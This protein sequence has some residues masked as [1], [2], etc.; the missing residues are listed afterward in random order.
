MKPSNEPPDPTNPDPVAYIK[1]WFMY[2]KERMREKRQPRP[3]PQNHQL[4][5][6]QNTQR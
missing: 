3:Q 5:S 2:G 1:A 4:F 6:I